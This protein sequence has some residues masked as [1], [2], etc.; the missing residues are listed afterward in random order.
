MQNM[1]IRQIEHVGVVVN[2]LPAAKAFF[3]AFGF[4]VQW[5]GEMQGELVDRV[6][7]LHDVKSA[8][9]FMGLPEGQG[10]LELVKFH[11]PSDECVQHPAA[12]TL[13]IRHIA[14]LVDDIEAVVAKLKERGAEMFSE[15]QTYENVYKLCYVRGPEG[16]I[17]ELA[18]QIK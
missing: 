2:D 16:I 18:E 6:V 14:F 5:E 11:T 13:G 9:V 10:K 4:K 1:R 12:N 7:G 17:L 3:L 8:V 15:V